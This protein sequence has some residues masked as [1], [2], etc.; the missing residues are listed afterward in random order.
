MVLWYTEEVEAKPYLFMVDGDEYER[1]GIT[2][3]PREKRDDDLPM[4]ADFEESL[5]EVSRNNLCR[6]VVQQ[7]ITMWQPH[8]GIPIAGANTT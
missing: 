1:R 8:P 6:D 7:L 4:D 5:R 2:P 3:G